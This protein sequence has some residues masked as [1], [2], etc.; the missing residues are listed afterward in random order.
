MEWKYLRQGKGLSVKNFVEEFRKKAL[1]LNISLHSTKTLLK[2]IGAFH[3][4]IR[5]TLLLLNPTYFDEVCVQAV[6]IE[7]RQKDA[8][9]GSSKEFSQQNGSK[10][11]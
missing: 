8:K 1:A 10:N 11:K 9:D 2:Y 7:S 4:Y 3:S 5:H 6:H